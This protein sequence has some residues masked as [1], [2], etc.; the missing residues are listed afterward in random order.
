M[1]RFLV[2]L[3]FPLIF[4]ASVP[5]EISEGRYEKKGNTEESDSNGAVDYLEIEQIN[6]KTLRFVYESWHTNGHVCRV[7]GSAQHVADSIHEYVESI[8]DEAA[9]WITDP[10]C[11]LRLY[12]KDNFVVIED[13]YNTCRI[14]HCGA[15]GYIGSD[16]FS[17]NSKKSLAG[18]AL[19]NW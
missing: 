8:P 2:L 17:K 10:K 9:P 15:R 14:I 5:L 6:D 19:P 11:N 1:T 12:N 13:V 3:V 7:H 4:A 18:P 16:S